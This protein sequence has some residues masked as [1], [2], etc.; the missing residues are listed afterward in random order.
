MKRNVLIALQV[1]G[2]AAAFAYLFS[3]VDVSKV[4]DAALGI[5]WIYTV[6]ALALTV[7]GLVVG[8]IRWRVMLR[9]YG[10]PSRPPLIELIRLYF[11][12]IFYNT[13]LPGGVG[14]DVVRGVITRKSFGEAGATSAVTVVLVERVLGLAALLAIV[15]SV[16]IVA[17]PEGLDHILVYAVL[18][19]VGAFTAVIGIALARRLAEVFPIAR[20]RPLLRSLP[21]LHAP[22]WFGVAIL[23]SLGTQLLMA[24]VGWALL[25]GLAPGFRLADAIVIV[26]LANA[27]A[28]LPIS[29]GGAGA[30]EAVFV[31]LATTAT[32]L[33]DTRAAT[34]SM[35][36]WGCILL[37]GAVGGLL[38]LRG[39]SQKADD[40]D[41]D[42]PHG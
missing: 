26:P 25:L 29:V 40:V 34:A 12:A 17:P 20:L 9:A 23:L 5:P 10:A 2:S 22:R 35:T 7:S 33:D 18:G 6:S 3:R 14:G 24:L 13:Y 16:L 42:V 30:R 27:T 41:P 37:V 21:V 19:I 1:L 15:A 31:A 8:A 32:T 28:F 11:V 4:W 36:M 38:Q 39:R